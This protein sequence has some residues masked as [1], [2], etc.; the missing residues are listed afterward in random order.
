MVQLL[1]RVRWS[2]NSV[3]GQLASLLCVGGPLCSRENPERQETPNGIPGVH[4]NWV[5]QD[6][7]AMARPWESNVHSHQLA[8]AFKQHGIGMILNL[9]EV[10]VHP[11]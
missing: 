1:G 4:S 9:Q 11:N 6:V 5:G 3:Y 2:F 8:H 10:G 7:L